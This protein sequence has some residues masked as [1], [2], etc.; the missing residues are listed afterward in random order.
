MLTVGL[1]ECQTGGRERNWRSHTLIP[2]EN[3]EGL[4]YNTGSET[5]SK[6]KEGEFLSQEKR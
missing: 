3:E 1:K 6:K 2:D 5:V 4:S